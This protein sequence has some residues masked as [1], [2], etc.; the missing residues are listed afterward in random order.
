MS[1]AYQS[2]PLPQGL[3]IPVSDGPQTTTVRDEFLS[4]LKCVDALAARLRR[5]T[6]TLKL[7]RARTPTRI[8]DWLSSHGI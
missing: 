8:K 4:L 1:P 6:E 3:G 7:G 5:D 2:T